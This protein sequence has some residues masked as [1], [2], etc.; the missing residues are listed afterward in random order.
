MEHIIGT[1]YFMAPEVLDG[2]YDTQCD[3]WSA[4]VLLYMFTSGYLPF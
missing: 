3:N 1:P 4:G 2:I